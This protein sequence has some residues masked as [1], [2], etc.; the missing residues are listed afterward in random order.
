MCGRLNEQ[1]NIHPFCQATKVVWPQGGTRGKGMDSLSL[2]DF[3]V[4]VECADVPILDQ[5]SS[6]G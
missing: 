4:A 3:K 6:C 5:M 2:T 1:L